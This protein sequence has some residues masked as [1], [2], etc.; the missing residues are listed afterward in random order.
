MYKNKTGDELLK[1]DTQETKRSPPLSEEVP[2]QIT[3]IGLGQGRLQYEYVQYN[4]WAIWAARLIQ[5]VSTLYL[6]RDTASAVCVLYLIASEVEP[7]TD[8]VPRI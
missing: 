2:Y 1:Q 7:D 8:C 3:L 6:G 4:T 5:T